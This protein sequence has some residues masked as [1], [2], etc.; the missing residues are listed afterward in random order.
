MEKQGQEENGVEVHA[1]SKVAAA[2]NV[3]VQT[4][5]L[6]ERLGHLHA[7]RSPGG[8]RLFSEMEMRKAIDLAVK[9]R[10]QRDPVIQPGSASA[11][12]ASTGIR[13]KRAR[14]EKGLTQAEAAVRAGISRSF[15]AAIERGESGVS[16]QTLARL[17]DAFS[18]PMSKFAGPVLLAG[19]VMRVAD[20]PRTETAG[21][22]TWEELAAPGSH[23]MEPALLIIPPAQTSGGVVLRPGAIFAYML[24]GEVV[25]EFGDTGETSR[26]MPG[27]AMMANSG[28]PLAWRNDGQTEARCLWVEMIVPPRPEI[29]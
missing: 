21:G 5:R 19:H 23:D 28:T 12:L 13:I 14:L 8:Q 2:A 15:I 22:V 26:L 3:S 7:L 6:W 4:V 9:K 25:F 24:A 11:E 27:D 10:R 29:C 17:A 20:R 18:I 1:I 16:V